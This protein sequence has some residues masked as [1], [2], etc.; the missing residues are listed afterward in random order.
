ML[1]QAYAEVK[2]QKYSEAKASAI[3]ARQLAEIARD[4]ALKK[5]PGK[6]EGVGLREEEPKF[7]E[8]GFTEEVLAGAT[9][10]GALGEGITISQLSTVYFDFDEYIL[11]EEARET[12]NENAEWLREHPGAKI[13]IEGHC[14][15]RG[16]VEYNLALGQKRAESTRDYLVTL[17]ID[18]KQMSTISYGEEVPADPD[19]N[20][21]AWVKNRRAEF[22]ILND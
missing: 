13:Q 21:Q 10:K 16:T 8:S 6:E 22:V 19:H 12:L 1:T 17:G 20:E 2:E 15:E 3:S 18:N 14:D 5:K 9:G 4:A 11:T 7:G